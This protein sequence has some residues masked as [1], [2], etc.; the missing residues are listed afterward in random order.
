MGMWY[1]GERV[2]A[3]PYDDGEL[4]V[5]RVVNS[6]ENEQGWKSVQFVSTTTVLI[7][8]KLFM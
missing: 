6:T 5:T 2:A 4:T 7:I 3:K 8:C 1:V